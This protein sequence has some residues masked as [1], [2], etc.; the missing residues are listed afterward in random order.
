VKRF[1]LGSTLVL[2]VTLFVLCKTQPLTSEGIITQCA[3]AM[4][5]IAKISEVKTLRIKAVYPDHGDHPLAYEMKRPNLSMNPTINLVFDGKRACFLK[6]QDNQSA[7]E[8]VNAEEWKD[9][10]KENALRFPAFFDYP[11]EY[12]GEEILNEKTYYKL[13]VVLPLGVKMIYFIDKESFLIAKITADFVL[14][15]KE[16]HAEQKCSDYREVDGILFPRGFTYGSRTGQMKGWVHSIEVNFP[17][18][19]DYFKVPADID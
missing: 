10:E 16:H 9:F 5:G 17:A 3:E 18:S 7:P 4:G 12:T 15:G 19:D 8:L 2:A 1:L 11:A 6:G 14:Y 13:A